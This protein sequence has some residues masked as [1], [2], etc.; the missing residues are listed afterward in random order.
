M[1]GLKIRLYPCFE[2]ARSLLGFVQPSYNYKKGL[3]VHILQFQG[4][5]YSRFFVLSDL[6]GVSKKKPVFRKFQSAGAIG[7]N[8]F[9]K[10]IKL[11][12]E[13]TFLYASRSK[14]LIPIPKVDPYMNTPNLYT[15]YKT[16]FVKFLRSKF[17]LEVIG[18]NL[19]AS[20]RCLF[21]YA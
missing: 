21:P 17:S 20:T 2:L 6:Q 8:H 16:D 3:L 14:R 18:R 1:D 15:S 5:L 12:C 7:K 4:L 11:S 9:R 19:K 10:K 13:I